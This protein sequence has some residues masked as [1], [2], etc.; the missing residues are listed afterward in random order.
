MSGLLKEGEL[1]LDRNGMRSDGVDDADAEALHG[2][3]DARGSIAHAV[4]DLIRKQL[5][6]GV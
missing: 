6:P 3:R 4:E 2:A 5:G 1:Q